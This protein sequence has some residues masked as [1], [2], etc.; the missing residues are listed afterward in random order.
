[1]N[2]QQA[3]NLTSLI[4]CFFKQHIY[5]CFLLSMLRPIYFLKL[6]L[7]RKLIFLLYWS[8]AAISVPG[9]SLV[10]VCVFFVMYTLLIKK[11][12]KRLRKMK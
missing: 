10:C 1:M 4:I 9:E 3:N 7:F 2:K 6:F 11:Q 8:L 5:F 12:G